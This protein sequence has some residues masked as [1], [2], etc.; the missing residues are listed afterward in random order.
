MVRRGEYLERAVVVPHGE[1]TVD[2][3]FHRGDRVTGVLVVPPHPTRGSME[4]PVIAEV[5]WASARAGHPTLRFNYP[6]VGASAGTFDTASAIAATEAAHEH[7]RMSLH[8]EASE[9]SIVGLGV[10]WGAEVVAGA[11]GRFARMILVQ[12]TYAAW[13][14]LDAYPGPIRAFFAE[15][16]DR[17]VRDAAIRAAQQCRDANVSVV[18]GADAAFRAGLVRLGQVIVE[19]LT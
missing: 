18:A 13:A 4:L 17:E 12:P 5:A 14:A 9:P 7:L 6:G 16:D 19:T 1:S 11:R 8:L 10:G 15:A 2:G 3:L